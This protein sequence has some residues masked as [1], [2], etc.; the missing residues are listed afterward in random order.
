MSDIARL[1]EILEAEAQGYSA[2][3]TRLPLKTALIKKGQLAALEAFHARE[4]DDQVKLRNLERA[5]TEVSS[6]IAARHGLTPDATLAQILE[7]LPTEQRFKLSS[8]RDR[9]IEQSMKLKEGNERCE[10]LLHA[11]LEFVKYSLELVGTILNPEERL[12][13]MLYGPEVPGPAKF[14][15][16]LLNRTA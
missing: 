4:A 14:G 3:V 9:L 1:E 15:S 8:L 13:D 6:A 11:S 5:R 16:V 2:F 7:K 10:I 12:A